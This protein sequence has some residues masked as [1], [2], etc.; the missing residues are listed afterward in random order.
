M[1]EMKPTVGHLVLLVLDVARGPSPRT[2]VSLLLFARARRCVST[3][4]L[5]LLLEVCGVA[6]LRD[7]VGPMYHRFR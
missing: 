3:H 7:L 4:L 2:F 6:A 5:F 1:P